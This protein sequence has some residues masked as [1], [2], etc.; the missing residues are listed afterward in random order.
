[1]ENVDPAGA[2]DDAIQVVRLA[3]NRVNEL[4]LHIETVEFED[5]AG[6]LIQIRKALETVRVIDAGLVRHIGSLRYGLAEVPGVGAFKIARGTDRKHWDSRGV[7][8]AIIDHKMDERGGEA[9]EQPWDVAEWILEAAGVSYW[10]TTSLRAMHID[11]DNYCTATRGQ[12]SVQI[13]NAATTEP[14]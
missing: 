8:G 11:P 1:M 6:M 12:L 4:L 10:R 9:V 7:I 3:L 5:A 13:V 2:L 14:E